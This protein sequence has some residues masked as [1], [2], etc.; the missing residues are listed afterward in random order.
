MH[1]ANMMKFIRTI[2]RIFRW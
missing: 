2:W 1:L